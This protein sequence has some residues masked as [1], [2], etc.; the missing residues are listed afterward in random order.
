M[1]TLLTHLKLAACFAGGAL[2]VTAIQVAPLKASTSA[3]SGV[4]IGLGHYATWGWTANPGTVKEHS[5]LFRVDFD[6]GVASTAVNTV[7]AGKS[8]GFTV[9]PVETA[10][11]T[12]KDGPTPGM[13]A[14][15]FGKEAIL[16]VPANSGNTFFVSDG[17]SGF[18][19]VCQRV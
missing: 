13:Y 12:L 3:P 9:E 16:V 1:K 11:F 6:R 18:S 17:N 8:R 14:M 7:T 2:L 19:G 10:L 15:Q 4:C 5:E